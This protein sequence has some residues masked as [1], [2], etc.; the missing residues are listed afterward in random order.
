[1]KSAM[2]M[3]LQGSCAGCSLPGWPS[4]V[5]WVLPGGRWWKKKEQSLDLEPRERAAGREVA[6]PYEA[7]CMGALQCSLSPCCESGREALD[8]VLG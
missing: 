6:I 3:V 5:H 1:M 2:G 7:P 8:T 4:R